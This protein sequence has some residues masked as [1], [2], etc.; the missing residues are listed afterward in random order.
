[1][2]IYSCLERF[3]VIELAPSIALV[4]SFFSFLS[5]FPSIFLQ[6]T[7][8]CGSLTVQLLEEVSKDQV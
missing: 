8:L 4:C 5:E 7:S 3:Y 1:M 2:I 6:L